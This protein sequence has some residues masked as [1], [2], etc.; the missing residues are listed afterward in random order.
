M[1]KLFVLLIL[2]SSF[3][4]AQDITESENKLTG[5]LYTDSRITLEEFN[6]PSL[7]VFI[8]M[9]ANKKSPFLAGVLSLIIPGAGEIY[10]GEYLKA[11]VFIALEAGLVTAGLIY[12]KKG[13]DKTTEFQ[14]Y[15]DQNWDVVKYAD[16]IVDNTQQEIGIDKNTQGLLPWERVNWQQL[17]NAE[18]N[19]GSILGGGFS[20]TLPPHGDQQ[21]FEMIG[22]YRQ[23]SPGW[24]DYNTLEN[25]SNWNLTTANMLFYAGERGKANDYYNTASAF[26]IGIYINHFLSALDGVWSAINYNDNLAVNMR[27]QG[28]QFTDHYEYI[29]TLHLKYSF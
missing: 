12:D 23:Y 2:H 18:R 6:E 20:H 27:V 25:G 9:Q 11:A 10:T 26:V 17:N 1:K 8:P 7:P 19:A 3:A 22:K 15:A 5:I 16:W 14:N 29:P 24:N 4:F 13:D 21:Y 28:Q